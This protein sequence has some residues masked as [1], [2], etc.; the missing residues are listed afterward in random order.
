M[1][2][3][4]SF[5][6]WNK[7]KQ[8]FE[9]EY[10]EQYMKNKPKDGRRKYDVPE[11]DIYCF[12]LLDNDI[13]QIKENY[14]E[15]FHEVFLD[16]PKDDLLLIQ[17]TGLDDVDGDKIYE[18]DIVKRVPTDSGFRFGCTETLYIVYW[19][20]CE[21]LILE[22]SEYESMNLHGDEESLNYY[23]KSLGEF[24][25]MGNIFQNYNIL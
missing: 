3:E 6:L 23:G 16:N 4:I 2:R 15:M 20:D 22:K 10:Y 18:F 13:Y 24:K 14:D 5:R 9:D 19:H 12:T 11:P 8:R 25:K 1:E 7:T 17:Y 21:Y